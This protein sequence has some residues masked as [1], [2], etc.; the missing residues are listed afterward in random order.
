MAPLDYAERNAHDDVAKYLRG[1]A[2]IDIIKVLE[3]EGA[4]LHA[5]DDVTP[6]K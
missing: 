3:E 5:K 1:R 4:D 6:D 2:G